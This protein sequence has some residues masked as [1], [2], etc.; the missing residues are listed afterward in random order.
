MPSRAWGSAPLA[1]LWNIIPRLLRWL[2]RLYSG[3]RVWNWDVRLRRSRDIR[4]WRWRWNVGLWRIWVGNI[5]HHIQSITECQEAG[6]RAL[7]LARARPD[8]LGC[9][10]L[11][12]DQAQVTQAADRAHQGPLTPDL[13]ASTFQPCIAPLWTFSKASPHS[14]CSSLERDLFGTV[15]LVRNWGRIGTTGR[16]LVEV[17]PTEIEA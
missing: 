16:E 8:Q 1:Y 5:R 17:Y 6:H 14:N 15:R 13:Q 4:L 3:F 2:R 9:H 7:R 11:G 12:Q 10:P